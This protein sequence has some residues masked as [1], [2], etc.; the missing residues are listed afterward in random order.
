KITSS[1]LELTEDGSR[2]EQQIGLRFTDIA[3][4]PGARIDEATLQFQADE[5]TTIQTS[6]IISG[7]DTDDA[8]TFTGTNSDISSRPRTTAQI[9]WTPPTWTVGDAGVDQRSP[10]LSAVVQ[11][12]IDR[13]DWIEGNAVAFLIEGTGK[14][15]AESFDGTQPPRLQVA[16]TH[17]VSV[18][19][20]DDMAR[21]G[22]PV[23]PGQ[24][25]F[26]R[27]GPVDQPLVVS[28]AASGSAEADLD[29]SSLGGSMTIPAG[30][31]SASIDVTPITDTLAEGS[32]SVIVT[33]LDGVGYVAGEPSTATVTIADADTP[34]VSVSLFDGVAIEGAQP[35]DIGQVV[36]T[37]S[38]GTELPL[39]VS[40]ATSGSATN[41][42]DYELRTG[43]FTF[44]AGVSSYTLD[45]VPVEDSVSEMTESIIVTVLESGAHTAGDPAEVTVHLVDNEVSLVRRVSASAGDAEEA[46]NG[47]ISLT[48]STLELVD[49]GPTS[50]HVGLRFGDVSVPQ[51]AIITSATVQFQ[52]ADPA[53]G[54]ASLVIEAQAADDASVFAGTSFDISTR[55]RTVA[56]VSWNPPDWVDDRL[57]GLGQRTPD[58]TSIIQEVVDRPGWN[59]GNGLSL[60]VSGSGTRPAV[61]FD[62]DPTAAP[63]LRIEYAGFGSPA[64]QAPV[65]N[66][67]ADSSFHPEPVVLGGVVADDQLPDP[68]TP[69]TIAWTQLAGPGASTF[70]DP[71]SLDTTV[72]F[73]QPGSY[74]LRLSV[75][76]G[77][78]VTVDDVVISS[79][80]PAVPQPEMVAAAV[81]GDYGSGCCEEGDVANLIGTLDPDI[82]VTTGDNRYVNGID[83]AIGQFYAPYIGNYQGTYG[84]GAPLNRFFPAIGNHEYSE[85]GGIDVYLDYF[86]L[87]GGGRVSSDSSGTERYY[88]YVVGPVH[89]FVVNSDSDEP[90]GV[91]ASSVQAQ[92]LQS[93]LAAST[94]P[95]QVVYMHHPPYSSGQRH[96]PSVEL[97]WPF[98]QWGGD[99][100]LAGHDHI[101]E[102]IV[103]GDLPYF[104]VGVSGNGLSGIS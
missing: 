17:A 79:V 76:D 24:F 21:E 94:A 26:T 92:W 62:G 38:E 27:T 28:Y 82:I 59:S 7:D 9:V 31:M 71:S 83:Y 102:R 55:P 10:D 30:A 103:K 42:E 8:L 54:A 5:S 68:S 65:I 84:A 60:I 23:D 53:L 57:A 29:Y 70:A 41:G 46:S 25:T 104:V 15:V 48:G 77:E 45:L 91:T 99:A 96:G 89:F 36:F 52:S 6:L 14:R 85:F 32:E 20:T 72:T 22:E 73:S 75:D 16:F 49:A 66:A 12:L 18:L 61:A 50:Q 67:S 86:T 78:L 80:D 11:E 43:S 101:Y 40:Y 88:D 19:A 2:G 87:P 51:G 35:A 3:I 97:Q 100:V 33:V 64:N 93:A 90:D 74:T 34:A 81:I 56:A 37:R 39:A 4:P 95:W 63:E 98:D 44:P 47:A 69:P 1:D 13:P 58:L